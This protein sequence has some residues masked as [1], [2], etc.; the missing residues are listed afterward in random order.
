M[1]RH[2]PDEWRPGAVILDLY[3]VREVIR[4]G[5]MGLVYRILHRDWNVEL[6]VKVPRPALA[7]TEKGL[8]D[9][10]TEA[11]TWVGLDEH[12]HTVNC[13]YVRTLGGV[14]TVFAEWLDGGS[15]AEAV[16]DEHL[17]TGGHR[18]VLRR[19]LDIAVQS[20]WGLRHA[21]RHGLIHQDVK[22]ANVLLARDGTAKVTDFGL[23]KARAAAGESTVVPP[24]ASV[25]AGYGGMTPAF[26]SPEQAEA[27]MWTEDSGRPRPQLTR[28]TDTWSWA[29]TVLEMFVGHPPC[30]YGQTGAEVLA[31]FVAEEIRDERMPAI[32][33]IP[34]GLVTLLGRCLAW[35]PADRPKDMGELAG[36]LAE[37]YATA[38][39]EPY[40]RPEP[41]TAV[42]LAD[43]L[44]NQALSLVDLGRADEAEALWRRASETDPHN[45]HAAYNR[46]LY[47]WRAGRLTDAQVIVDLEGVREAHP[48]EWRPGYLL[49][50][51]HLER[52]DAESAAELLRA[53][54]ERAPGTPEITDALG[55]ADRAPR[56]GPDTVLIG[57]TGIVYGVAVSR[58][59]RTGVSA[60][61]DGTVRVWDLVG[62]RCVRV[63]TA[64]D[65]EWGIYGLA[66]DAAARRAIT[67]APDGAARIWD[68][69]TGGLLHT[70]DH[71]ANPVKFAP[72]DVAMSGDGLIALTAHNNGVVQVWDT[73]TGRCLRELTSGPDGTRVGGTA[74]GL[75]LSADG[76][77]A[78]TRDRRT[79]G[80]DAGLL[81]WDPGTGQV[82]RTIETRFR[83][84][85][86]SADGRTA[87]TSVGGSG[88]RIWDVATGR[89][90][91]PAVV[92]PGG[93]GYY[94]GVSADGR[95]AL[96]GATNTTELWE[97]SAGRCFRSWR[98]GGYSVAFG[99]DGLLALTGGAHGRLTLRE[100]APPGPPAP[101]SYPL[102]RAATERV[103]E[104][105][106]VRRALDRTTALMDE[107]RAGAAADELRRARAVPGYRRHHALLDSWQAVTGAGRRTTLSDA[108][109]RA[110]PPIIGV[111]PHS[112]HEAAGLLPLNSGRGL[113]E[114]VSR[115]DGTRLDLWDLRDG[116]RRV[117]A[118]GDI[119][120]FRDLAVPADDG[121]VLS[122]GAD[123]T[124][125]G[126]DLESGRDRHTLRG[127]T[128]RMYKVALD[129]GGRVALSAGKDR[130]IR[131]WDLETETCVRELTGH[132]AFVSTL[133]MSDDGRYAFS[134]GDDGPRIWDVRA[135]RCLHVL[136]GEKWSE[137]ALSGNGDTLLT[138]HWDGTVR[139]W[140]VRTG[141]CRH[142]MTGHDPEKT[143]VGLACSADGGVGVSVSQD[144]TMRTWD[145]RTGR[146]RHVARIN[147][148][149]PA[150][151]VSGVEVSAD[152]RFAVSGGAEGLLRVWDLDTG[153][154]L[155][156]LDAHASGIMWLA[157]TGGGRVIL[158]RDRE[159]VTRVWELD[160]EYDF[161]PPPP[162]P[163]ATPPAPPVRSTWFAR[164]PGVS[165]L[166]R[167]SRS[168]RGVS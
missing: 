95:Y 152:G 25:L 91:R 58:D 15:L 142:T 17:Y 10:E 100:P 105:E 86:L 54:A 115:A 94:Y 19:I 163:P 132:T 130:V 147:R 73:E 46:G 88:V 143:L 159:G 38:L 78:L 139:V 101:W 137:F 23:A 104:S 166:T 57:H 122:A 71:G 110:T 68:L 67:A 49:G 26:C 42:R 106:V 125:H 4:S 21:H 148:G 167:S 153:A 102:P 149:F 55:R 116:G 48:E 69:R 75:A 155:R 146:C 16:R 83:D 70:L 140:D 127:T 74:H 151:A 121:I 126:W 114:L 61:T 82:L 72:G 133:A 135:G 51:V 117:L 50:L 66:A 76:R 64:T 87:V 96:G 89:E 31:A 20:A 160:W 156:T 59:G 162:P 154:C 28:A 52:G 41:L 113:L 11:A 124:V 45:P 47:L 39:G 141:I 8:R 90:R 30:R 9:F 109:L 119:D 97:L 123:G 35:V 150:F 111:G 60:A 5:G 24:G 84:A 34:A 2:V 33:A 53:A 7:A 44:S 13:V 138:G 161:S 65:S 99:T 6:A 158:S 32:P 144:Q 36:E 134:Y 108:W 164:L 168:S 118:R 43:G 145:P 80:P 98:E 18:E 112:A 131:V 62:R 56:T 85:A 29:L 1:A 22:P 93:L 40:P 103:R 27:A 37:I 77:V 79:S 165:R 120:T 92:R 14:P 81:V 107:G 129:A 63:I 128:G 157:I 12:P 3:E 136:N